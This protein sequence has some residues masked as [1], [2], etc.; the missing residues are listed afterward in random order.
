MQRTFG[1]VQQALPTFAGRS[2]V[3]SWIHG[4]AYHLYVD[5]RRVQQRTEPRPD[6]WWEA[7][8]SPHAAPDQLVAQAD[9]SNAVY[10]AV[11]QLDPDQRD[12]VHLHYYQGLTLQE[13]ADAMEVAISTVKYR[14][15]QAL[16]QLQK[17]LGSSDPAAKSSTDLKAL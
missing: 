4:I 3:S 16:V 9:L 17:Q 10:A 15:R 12:C 2:S 13:T 8:P 6:E 5:W 11:D 1:R 14:L 7:C